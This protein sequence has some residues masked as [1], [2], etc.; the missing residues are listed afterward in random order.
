MFK[1]K[2][3]VLSL[4]MLSMFVLLPGTAFASSSSG[5]VNCN[6]YLNVRQS[7]TTDAKIVAKLYPGTQISI[8]DSENNWYKITYAGSEAWVASEYVSIESTAAPDSGD[9]DKILSVASYAQKYL[10]VR[11]VYGGTSAKGFDCSGLTMSIFSNIGINLP[12]SASRQANQGTVIKK[13]DLKQGDLVFFDTDGG[14]NSISHVG[15]Y[16]GNDKFIHAASAPTSRVVI[17]SLNQS[18]YASRYMT[19]RR[20][21]N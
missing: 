16:I 14:H 20:I 17:S 11:Y 15:I 6:G 8:E 2:V 5:T 1:L 19:A 7:P 10:G 21:I 9:S 12:H 3:M 4:A 18:Y 13:S